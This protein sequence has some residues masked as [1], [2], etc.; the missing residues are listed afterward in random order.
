[1]RSRSKARSYLSSSP[2]LCGPNALGRYNILARYYDPPIAQFLTL[3]PDVASTLSPYGYVAGD[4]LNS[5]D[6]TGLCVWIGCNVQSFLNQNGFCTNGQNNC[7]TGAQAVSGAISD[8]DPNLVYNLTD[9]HP[10]GVVAFVRNASVLVSLGTDVGNQIDGRSVPASDWVIDALG[11]V[12]F[13]S[14]AAKGA[15]ALTD[16]G[17]IPA[18]ARLWNLS[19]DLRGTRAKPHDWQRTRLPRATS[20]RNQK[21]REPWRLR[22]LMQVLGALLGCSVLALGQVWFRR[23]EAAGHQPLTKALPVLGML[24][25]FLI[26][27][28][29]TGVIGG[30]TIE[31]PVVFDVVV[32]GL[33]LI[34]GAAVGVFLAHDY[35]KRK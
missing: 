31:H 14:V 17:L 32:V 23:S 29:G 25:A 9:P 35:Y 18:A 26:A 24:I 6:P 4:P 27:G 3:D 12:P 11:F 28:V 21:Q 13:S 20:G 1:M 34:I 5:A 19:L 7:E 30:S 22:E 16:S 10:S 15:E 33:A 8:V 2:S